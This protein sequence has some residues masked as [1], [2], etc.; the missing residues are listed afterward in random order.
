[1]GTLCDIAAELSNG[2]F[3][4][5]NTIQ[6]LQLTATAGDVKTYHLELQDGTIC[7][8][9]LN[10]NDII[11]VSL[12]AVPNDA[13]PINHILAQ[14]VTILNEQS[15]LSQVQILATQVAGD[16]L[17]AN[18]AKNLILGLNYAAGL[19]GTGVVYDSGTN[20]LTVAVGADNTTAFTTTFDP[21]GID[22]DAYDMD[23]MTEG[24]NNHLLTTA[25][26]TKLN[27][28]E[29][30]ATG[31]LT[32]AEI[33][34]LLNAEVDMNLLSDL[35]VIKLDSVENGAQPDQTGAEMITLITAEAD[36]N[37]PNDVQMQQF[38]DLILYA[39]EAGE[40]TG[41]LSRTQSTM[42]FVNATRTFTI[43]PTGADAVGYIKSDRFVFSGATDLVI[44]DVQG[45]H[46]IYM[47]AAGVLDEVGVFDVDTL[48][49]NNCYIAA[50]Y[51]D[52][53]AQE[54]VYIGDERHGTVM[55]W[56]THSYLHMNEGTR[57]A[58]GFELSDITPDG[59]GSL[60]THARLQVADGLIFDEDLDHYIINTAPQT[61]APIANIPF[62]Y[63]DGTDNFKKL[64]ATDYVV[65]PSGTGRATYNLN[66]AGVW[67]L[68]EITNNRWMCMHMFATND[69][70]EP[71]IYIMGIAEYDDVNDASTGAATESRTVADAIPIQELAPIGVLVIRSRDTFTNAVRST[72]VT[73]TDGSSYL[74]LR[75]GVDKSL[76]AATPLAQTLPPTLS[77]T[78]TTFESVD[79]DITITN[80]DAAFTYNVITSIGTVARVGNTITVSPGAV[81]AD[82]PSTVSVTATEVGKTVSVNSVH[83]FTVTDARTATPTLTG[84]GTTNENVD[85]DVTITNYDAGFTYGITTSI[86]TV[87]RIGNII[88]VSPGSVDT[89]TPSTLTVTA[90]DPG[91]TISLDAV[92]N[93]TV[94][95]IQTADP[96]LSGSGNVN[97]NTDYDVTI[98]N[99]NAAYTYTVTTSIGSYVRTGNTIT[100]SPGLVSANT[101]ST[102][103]ISA[104][105]PGQDPSND[106]VHN[107][108]VD[109]TQTTAPTLTGSGSVTESNDY[110]V[111][112]SNYNGTFTYGITLSHGT[113][114]RTNDVIT[115]S[116]PAVAGDAPATVTVNATEA[117]NTISSNTVHNY[118][119]LNTV[120][121]NDTDYYLDIS[122]AAINGTNIPTI[123]GPGDLVTSGTQN[124]RNKGALSFDAILYT[125]T[126][127]SQD[128]VTGLST[129]DFTQAINGS[130]FYHDRVAGD[131]I[132]KND[133]G[134]I[135]E[136]GNI[137]FKDVV[138][139]DGICEV[140]IKSRSIVA[141]N[142]IVD[143][144]R[145]P[146]ETIFSDL[147]DAE[148]ATNT[149]R[150][151][152]FNSTGFTVGTAGGVNQNLA[153]YIAYVTLYTYIA[154]GL[155]N[156]G[157]RYIVAYNPVTNKTLPLYIG[158]GLDGH[159]IPHFVG[160]V[161]E[162]AHFKNL[163]NAIAWRTPYGDFSEYMILND[164][165]ASALLPS[166][167]G[168]NIDSVT[169]DTSSTTNAVD[170]AYI[171]QGR[172]KSKT[173]TIVQYTGTGVAGNFVE[174]LDVD[175][176]AKKPAR[177]TFK[178]VSAVSNWPIM[179][180]ARGE[181]EVIYYNLSL[182]ESTTGD[183]T[184][185][186]NGFTVGGTASWQNTANV[187]YIALVEFDTYG[188]T[189]GSYIQSDVD[190][191][192]TTDIV[193]KSD[194]DGVWN[195]TQ[196]N[197]HLDSNLDNLLVS[198]DGTN[199]VLNRN[200][201]IGDEFYIGTKGTISLYTAVAGGTTHA[202]GLGFT[203]D[204]AVSRDALEL[205]ITFNN[206]TNYNALTKNANFTPTITGGPNDEFETALFLA[207][208]GVQDVTLSNITTGVDF[209]WLKNRDAADNHSICDSLTGYALKLI[210]NDTTAEA[211][212]ALSSF[213]SDGF[214]FLDNAVNDMNRADDNYVAWCASL[215]I[216]N[217]SNTDGTITSVTKS[218][219]FMS[220]I[221]Y[222]GNAALS[223][224]VGHSLG[225]I[226]EMIIYK[227]RGETTH[228]GVYH[229]DIGVG[230]IIFLS[231]TNA[232]GV[233]AAFIDTTVPTSTVFQLSSVDAGATCN[234]GN[235]TAYA[236]ASVAGRCKV[237]SVTITGGVM[238]G[239]TDLGFTLGFGMFKRTD[240]T[241]DWEIIDSESTNFLEANTTNTEAT[242]GADR[243]TVAG[244]V[245]SNNGLPDGSYI[246]VAISSSSEY[247]IKIRE[248]FDAIGPINEGLNV[249]ARITSTEIGTE[250]TAVYAA[251][252]ENL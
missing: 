57:I 139:V 73:H 170:N 105:D 6:D 86:G 150:V 156:H 85:Y 13:T 192:F 97:E 235:I 244:K 15:T 231:L 205:E 166:I 141:S 39:Q 56:A 145:G 67:S 169:I 208:G 176:V 151:K 221:T 245:I 186:S 247:D 185:N 24:V 14:I 29:A 53:A 201:T 146:I 42:S 115:V 204:I 181:S 234:N 127:T 112:I 137:A 199:M 183:T 27:G 194:A 134:T 28:I 91:Q 93:F 108:T 43:T 229:K 202:H 2:V 173:W 31:D 21:Q 138:G 37:I 159:E 48:F 153:T 96:I 33:F 143:G 177:V 88:T 227:N 191:I 128:I 49:K 164:T 38:Q 246:F 107:F 82:T 157:K 130:G 113:F 223:A 26:L 118:T 89:D 95:N 70:S 237:G 243:V 68:Q 162:L 206:G 47:N 64:P 116:V 135:I 232:A 30:G 1:M 213:N 117:G 106:V 174:T 84:A 132:V 17:S 163:S 209:L 79:Y 25:L 90:T 160:S 122:G 94:A 60:N 161:L 102:V 197:A 188:D 98:T 74:D 8:F 124:M 175:G 131:G 140:H 35:Q 114:V 200:V 121:A 211:L 214:S 120:I 4:S 154:W 12:T 220:A 83:N 34:N 41:L 171:M 52:V 158:S 81:V 242:N 5:E 99:Y 101:P 50:I 203:P 179:D 58:S 147:T 187:Q 104:T 136:S 250:T 189:G 196:L 193:T 69:V 230:K 129:I 19:P 3:D 217:A 9:D 144:L 55:D 224:T 180:N 195:G 178:A 66:T 248:T 249:G 198:A 142:L 59:D 100:V 241:G 45:L 32:A 168:T 184:F 87:A 238:S 210:P 240:S 239:D 110:D 7:D 165:S 216:D 103:T 76:V 126:G 172:A 233:N 226:P 71:I 61:L 219:S 65:H 75:L 236:F 152:A 207:N 22:G 215:P 228:W 63:R 44:T 18:N 222:T 78:G 123:T 190:A 125:G 46:F 155:T 212:S 251:L 23:N 182:A 80:Y 148:D 16:A 51:W 72:I 36:G 218:N 10:G 133:A 40:A 62:W 225:K 111:T 149:E 119:I 92:H 11:S 54:A 167:Y 252:T 77:G 20:T 109:N